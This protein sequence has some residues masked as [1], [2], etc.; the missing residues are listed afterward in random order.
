MNMEPH[1]N[2]SVPGNALDVSKDLNVPFIKALN[3]YGYLLDKG[4][5]GDFMKFVEAGHVDIGK[6][7]QSSNLGYKASLL[8]IAIKNNHKLAFDLLIKMGADFTMP[9][10]KKGTALGDA[11]A[12]DIS[13]F[14]ERIIGEGGINVDELHFSQKHGYKT[15]LLSIAIKNNHKF[16]FDLLMKMGA[17][18]NKP[19]EKNLT[20]KN[21]AVASSESEYLWSILSAEY[22]HKANLRPAK[23]PGTG[24]LGLKHEHK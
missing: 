1:I 3:A 19:D 8:S 6:L 5:E 9:D 20:A 22:D 16:A 11:V 12:S 7:Y 10:E 2:G 14:F 15:T 13:E 21:E 18:F 23:V 24:L 4:Y 17:D